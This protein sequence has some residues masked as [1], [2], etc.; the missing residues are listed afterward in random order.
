[1]DAGFRG[2]RIG[3]AQVSEKHCGFIINVGNATAADISE[4]MDEVIEKVKE[5]FDVALEPEI[6]RIGS[7]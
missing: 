5:K 3:G 6:V 4:L 2:Y 7:F 1:M